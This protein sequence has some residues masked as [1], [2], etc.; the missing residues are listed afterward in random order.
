MN[1]VCF[2]NDYLHVKW[3][4]T[5]RVEHKNKSRKRRKHEIQEPEW[6]NHSHNCN[7]KHVLGCNRKHFIDETSNLLANL[8]DLNLPPLPDVDIPWRWLHWVGR[9]YLWSLE[10][11]QNWNLRSDWRKLKLIQNIF[12][13]NLKLH[14]LKLI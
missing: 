12:F 11:D 13:Y 2:K 3:N 14:L 5:D 4:K 7:N 1:Q 8:F 6:N 10:K 9:K